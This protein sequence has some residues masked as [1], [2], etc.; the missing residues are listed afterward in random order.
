MVSFGDGT[1]GLRHTIDMD[2]EEV[3]VRLTTLTLFRRVP[4]AGL[5]VTYHLLEQVRTGWT[6]SYSHPYFLG[7][8][9]GLIR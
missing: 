1:I 2:G 8:L 5:S 4:A 7:Q 3:Q 9:L 6:G